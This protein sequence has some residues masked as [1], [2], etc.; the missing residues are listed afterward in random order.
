MTTFRIYHSHYL[1]LHFKMGTA[2]ILSLAINL[3]AVPIRT[4]KGYKK[5]AIFSSQLIMRMLEH[6]DWM[7]IHISDVYQC[8]ST[9]PYVF[10]H[11]H[12]FT[13]SINTSAHISLS[14]TYS[15]QTAWPAATWRRY[16]RIDALACAIYTSSRRAYIKGNNVRPF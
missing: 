10:K 7:M 4:Q 2:T 15:T 16:S 8:H 14:H 6:H 5:P 13:A 1:L 3:A 12:Y 9:V 11:L